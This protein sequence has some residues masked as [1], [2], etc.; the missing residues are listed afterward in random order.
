[1]LN[2]MEDSMLRL[3]VDEGYAF[4][5]LSIQEIKKDL[6]VQASTNYTRVLDTIRGQIYYDNFVAIMESEEY[7]ELLRVNKIL[8]DYV[9]KIRAGEFV[10]GKEV[11]DCNEM[12]YKA[13]Q[14]IQK[15]FFGTEL[16]SEVKSY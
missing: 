14:A 9:D 10:D 4:D 16:T 15:K 2:A 1:M 13:K 11:D 8:Y 5:Y 7:K 3:E 12:R 6:S